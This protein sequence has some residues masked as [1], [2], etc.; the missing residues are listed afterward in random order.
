MNLEY[1]DFVKAKICQA[2]TLGF[3]FPER[4]LNKNRNVHYP[5]GPLRGIARKRPE[6]I[7]IKN[8]ARVEVSDLPLISVCLCVLPLRES[9]LSVTR[10]RSE[11]R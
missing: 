4:K 1:E 6:Q 8:G 5:C 3:D 2:P 10:W 9:A 7:R 11:T